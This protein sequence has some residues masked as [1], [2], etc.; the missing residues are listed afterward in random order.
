VKQY[1]V[2]KKLKFNGGVAKIT[3]VN[4]DGT[5]TLNWSKPP[6]QNNGSATQS[7]GGF[8]G[9]LPSINIQKTKASLNGLKDTLTSEIGTLDD[10]Q[11]QEYKQAEKETLDR[12]YEIY[13]KEGFP[14]ELNIEQSR[15]RMHNML[16]TDHSFIQDPEDIPGGCKTCWASIKI[17]ENL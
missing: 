14:N 6:A 7:K 8:A 15:I 3:S 4:P 2:G 10:Y 5:A 12:Q 9:T 16:I 1:T 17:S 13:N 11:N